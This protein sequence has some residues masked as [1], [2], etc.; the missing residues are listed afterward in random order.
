MNR[1]QERVKCWTKPATLALTSGLF[2]D[3]TRSRADLLV[4]RKRN[5]TSTTDRVE[6]TNQAI[7]AN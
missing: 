7:S 2:S 1:P 5:I 3:L 4:D 6:L